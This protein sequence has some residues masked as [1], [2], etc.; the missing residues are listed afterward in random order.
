MFNKL[1]S[2]QRP[3]EDPAITNQ[4]SI[5]GINADPKLID[6]PAILVGDYVKLDADD[7]YCGD[8]PHQSAVTSNR[9]IDIEIYGLTTW[10]AVGAPY[11]ATVTYRLFTD[12]YHTIPAS[13]YTT[14]VGNYHQGDK[15]YITLPSA[16]YGFY[17]FDYL[18]K[19]ASGTI[20]ASNIV[21]SRPLNLWYDEPIDPNE[22]IFN[23]SATK[24]CSGSTLCLTTSYIPKTYYY[25]VCGAD[26]YTY[27]LTPVKIDW[28]DG[29]N[30]GTSLSYI[31]KRGG[32]GPGRSSDFI[33]PFD[34]LPSELCHTYTNSSAGSH[35]YN[36]TLELDNYLSQVQIPITITVGDHFDVKIDYDNNCSD[37]TTHLT[38]STYS[39]GTNTYAWSTSATT[40][41][42]PVTTAGSYSVTVT[43]S[44][45][46]TGVG[47]ITLDCVHCCR[48]SSGI[49][50]F[51]GSPSVPY[52]LNSIAA[53]SAGTTSEIALN[54]TLA[55]TSALTINNSPN[56][57]MGENAEIIVHSGKTLT[58]NNSHL[59]ACDKMW[60]GIYVEK[61]GTL[62]V[63]NT[64]IEDAIEG[65]HVEGNGHIEVIN[66]VFDRDNIGIGVW[67]SDFAKTD[68]IESNVFKCT[69]GNTLRAPYSGKRTLYGIAIY[70]VRGISIGDHLESTT[71]SNKFLS[72]N[73]GIAATS[74]DVSIYN[75]LFDKIKDY[76][77]VI[78]YIYEGKAISSYATVF[79]GT[80]SPP[81]LNVYTNPA[82]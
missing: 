50:S 62:I 81:I 76:N 27:Q 1:F 23:T 2:Q 60:K 20:I 8:F 63:N 11:E 37:I 80:T 14:V 46:C 38:A 51:D 18:V 9:N 15:I 13:V 22:V 70:K 75:N 29:T 10:T 45:S 30:T 3:I 68:K 55:N 71:T 33:D 57:S 73:N 64:T 25:N 49:L 54:G 41:T 19:N 36:A 58:I 21:P 35:I 52:N 34:P 72:I 26:Y 5:F 78:P 66:S 69:G 31:D 32:V 17:E 77:N 7:Q 48:E 65:I 4:F 24:I 47:S 61:G 53:L 59:K 39:F 82:E 28:G 74:S 40:A 12:L 6:F 42:I 56:I 16:G 67:N 44:S 79:Y 43:K